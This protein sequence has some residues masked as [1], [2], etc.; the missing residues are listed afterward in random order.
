[1][2][3]VAIIGNL[4]GGKSTLSNKISRA[5]GLTP[6]SIDKIQWGHNWAPI[7]TEEVLNKINKITAK[8]QWIIDGWGPWE[9]I[10]KRLQ[11]AD[12]VVIVDH[13]LWIHYWWATK[14][15]FKAMFVPSKVDSPKGCNY[16]SVTR[17]IYKMIPYIH[18]ELRPKLLELIE[19][20]DS[21]TAV[22]HIRSPRELKQ[23]YINHCSEQT[24]YQNP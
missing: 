13:D 6:H 11:L 18:R 2:K 22:H 4:G 16:L 7:P 24:K 15:Q 14:R 5:H 17:L 8:E 21:T 19:N 9:S 23:F 10:E 20:L 1:M 3:R 12:T